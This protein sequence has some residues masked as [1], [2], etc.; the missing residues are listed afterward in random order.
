VP[1]RQRHAY[2]ASPTS[3]ASGRWDAGSGGRHV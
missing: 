1:C 3:V 2:A